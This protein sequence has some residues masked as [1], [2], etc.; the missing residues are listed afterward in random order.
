MVVLVEIEGLVVKEVV[1]GGGGG[2][3]SSSNSFSSSIGS[4]YC[5]RNRSKYLFR[6][7]MR[8]ICTLLRERETNPMEWRFRRSWIFSLNR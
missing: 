5:V 1:N 2:S 8:K 6:K 4:I 3:S 7:N